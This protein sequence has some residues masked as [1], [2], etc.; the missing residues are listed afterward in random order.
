MPTNPAAALDALL[1]E[2]IPVEGTGEVVR[3]LS[4]AL[5]AQLDRIDSPLVGGGGETDAFALLPSL[6]LLCRGPQA[7]FGGR[8]M[9]RAVEWA[10][11]LPP[12]ALVAIRDAAER[13]I[14]AMV[15]VVPQSKKKAAKP[16][17]GSSSS[18]SGPA[19]STDGGSTT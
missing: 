9:E 15:D 10:D 4:L 17:A 8:L 19:A 18:R 1:P 5:Y 3:P 2:P 6:F 16:M 7:A 12:S 14:A 11:A 13:Q